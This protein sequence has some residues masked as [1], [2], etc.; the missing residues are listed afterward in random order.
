MLSLPQKPWRR[1]RITALGEDRFLMTFVAGVTGA[2][3]FEE[4]V[5]DDVH[6]CLGPADRILAED[7][8]ALSV[9][10]QL[11]DLVAFQRALVLQSILVER[12]R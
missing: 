10:L 5:S 11:R 9:T 3:A 6:V 12:G 8:D 2:A 7:P 4:A 1:V